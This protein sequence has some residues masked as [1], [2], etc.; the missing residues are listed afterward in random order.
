MSSVSTV[1]QLKQKIRTME[2]LSTTIGISRPTLSKHFQDAGSVPSRTRDPIEQALDT[3]DYIAKF[4]VTK[5]NRQSTRIIGVIVPYP[6]DLF[7]TSVAR[8][9]V[10][11]NRNHN[12]T[13][14]T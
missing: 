6:N 13:N 7:F 5:M 14:Y 2:E 12:G 9:L 4:F 1:G 11:L 10:Q 3:I 8:T